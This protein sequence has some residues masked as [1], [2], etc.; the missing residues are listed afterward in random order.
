MGYRLADN[1][2]DTLAVP[3]LVLT[4]LCLSLIHI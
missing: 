4:H 1:T 2:G 3:Q